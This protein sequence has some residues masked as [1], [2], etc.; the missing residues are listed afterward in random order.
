MKIDNP[1][2]FSINLDRAVVR[3]LLRE[4]CH[5]EDPGDVLITKVLDRCGGNP[6]NAPMIYKL[7]WH[8]LSVQTLRKRYKKSQLTKQE[9]QIIVQDKIDS[10][11]RQLETTSSTH[12]VLKLQE[13]I[14]SLEN[15][16]E[17]LKK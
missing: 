1:K 16:L 2:K 3:E 8:L 6:F 17:E 12:D 5:V 10:L 13:D 11:K 9:Q 15:H 14:R 4:Q 7:G